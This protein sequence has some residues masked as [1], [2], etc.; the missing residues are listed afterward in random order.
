[1]LNFAALDLILGLEGKLERAKLVAI[2]PFRDLQAA[3]NAGRMPLKIDLPGGRLG[4][5]AGFMSDVPDAV[6][7]RAA[8]HCAFE[9]LH[10]CQF[11]DPALPLP[12]APKLELLPEEW[13]RYRQDVERGLDRLSDRVAQL[14][15]DSHLIQVLPGADSLIRKLLGQIARKQVGKLDWAAHERTTVEL[16]LVVPNQRFEL[17]GRGPLGGV[18]SAP[19]ENESTLRWELITL[20]TFDHDTG[21]WSGGFVKDGRLDVDE[22]GKLFRPDQDFCEV[23][24]PTREQVDR[25]RQRPTARMELELKATD[26]G[27]TVAAARWELADGAT[28]LED[29]LNVS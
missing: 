12:P 4:G 14:I 21:E 19:V 7:F 28:P 1:M 20:A 17:D 10:A 13:T 16:R 15:V 23:T 5:F 22:D 26:R 24:L 6:E 25:A 29:E 3:E 9:F 18:D 11:L 2:A 8:R 27:T